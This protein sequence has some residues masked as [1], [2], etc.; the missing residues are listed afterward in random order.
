MKELSEI[1]ASHKTH[2]TIQVMQQ[3]FESEQLGKIIGYLEAK[4]HQCEVLERYEQIPNSLSCP[5]SKLLLAGAGDRG[6]QYLVETIKMNTMPDARVPVLLYLKHP[7][8][9]VDEEMLLASVDDFILAPL[10]L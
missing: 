9:D 2:N 5:D 4:G 1:K 6:L 7:P 3:A 8:R 10:N